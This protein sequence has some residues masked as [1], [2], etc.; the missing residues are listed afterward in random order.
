[1]NTGAG[2]TTPLVINKLRP[3]QNLMISDV[4]IVLDTYW[5]IFFIFLNEHKL[6]ILYNSLMR[7]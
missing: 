1:M 2:P 3:V 4:N 5:P 7:K 6:K